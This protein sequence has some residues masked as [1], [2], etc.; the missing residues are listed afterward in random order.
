[1]LCF[2]FVCLGFL[3]SPANP[4]GSYQD[5]YR[6]I[7]MPL[8]R[9]GGIHKGTMAYFYPPGTETGESREKF[10]KNAGE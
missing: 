7:Y 8:A 5:S 4:F 2:L 3:V 9:Q 1:M 10:G 6:P